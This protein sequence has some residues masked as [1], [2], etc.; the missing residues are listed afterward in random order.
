MSNNMTTS[1][2]VKWAAGFTVGVGVIIWMFATFVTKSEYERYISRD[3]NELKVDVRELKGGHNTIL[4]K[5]DNIETRMMFGKFS[6]NFI[7][8]F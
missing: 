8:G 1:Q 6:T 4:R 7:N 2:I 3:I 5:L